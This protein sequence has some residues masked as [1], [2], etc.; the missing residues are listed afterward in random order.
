[1]FTKT[2]LFIF[3][4]I[5]LFAVLFAG[6]PT[7]FFS[8]SYEASAGYQQEVAD[9][10][11]SA[12]VTIYSSLGSDN[13]TYQYSSYHDHPTA[14]EFSAGLPS[15]QYL[16]IWWGAEPILGKSGL[17]HTMVKAHGLIRIERDS[18]GMDKGS[19]VKVILF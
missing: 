11:D 9:T 19:P 8:I 14:P 7:D 16:E 12:N 18:E 10:L 3:S 1:M 13:M 5:G 15:G 4:F 17:I 2:A 6:I